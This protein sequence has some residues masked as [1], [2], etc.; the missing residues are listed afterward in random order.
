MNQ[1]QK[2][3]VICAVAIVV[4]MILYPPFN[5]T[6]PNGMIINAGYGWVFNPPRTEW[7]SNYIP[8]VNV[9]L[10]VAQWIAVIVAGLAAYY[11]TKD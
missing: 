10:L 9:G 5:L 1:K 11:F 2:R 4:I 6:L 8:S 7:G 3:V